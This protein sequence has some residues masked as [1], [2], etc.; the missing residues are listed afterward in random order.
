MKKEAVDKFTNEML[1]APKGTRD[2]LPEEKM[3]RDKV[4]SVLREAFELYGFAPIE[5]PVL[6][7]FEVLSSKYAGGSEILKETYKLKDQGDR[8]LGLRYDLTVPLCRVVARNQD[9]AMP[10]K[11]YAIAPVYRDGPLKLGRYREFYQCDADIIGAPKGLADAECLAVAATALE[12]LGL[13]FVL[14]INNRKILD[15]ILEYAG[16]EES[17]RTGAILAI[18]K[19]AKIGIEGVKKELLAERGLTVSATKKIEEILSLENDVLNEAEGKLTAQET[20]DLVL[21]KLNKKLAFIEIAKEGIGEVM[22][23]LD[24]LN[25]C[26]I[27]ERIQFDVSLARGL[28]YYTGS[29]YEGFLLNSQITSSICSGGR[30]DELIGKFAGKTDKIPAVGIS[31]GLDVVV[32]AIKLGNSATIKLDTKKSPADV[33]V[34]PIKTLPQSIKIAKE[35]RAAGI[36]TALDLMQRNIGKNM[37]FASKQGTPY[38]VIVGPKELEMGKITVKNMITGEEKKLSLKEAIKEIKN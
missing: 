12:K 21:E 7:R 34:I 18:D 16:V 10:F 17:K 11:R 14:K 33:F 19:L 31:V 13:N 6:E 22:E 5:T 28:A 25:E 3:L 36:K 23:L 1:D 9:L 29:I 15:G 8:D 37:E 4:T 35:L 30:Y 32:E 38:V 27:R 20:S 24:Y 26:E 2:F